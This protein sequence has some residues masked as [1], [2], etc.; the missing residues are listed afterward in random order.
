MGCQVQTVMTGIY[1]G[2]THRGQSTVRVGWRSNTGWALH[3][4][5]RV[6]SMRDSCHISKRSI[7]SLGVMRSRGKIRWL[8]TL[9]RCSSNTPI[10]T[11]TLYRRPMSFQKSIRS[12]SML[13]SREYLPTIEVSTAEVRLGKS[14]RICGSLSLLA[15]QE[16]VASIL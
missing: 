9:R 2:P 15:L 4:L 10:T 6:I 14:L 1:S 7:T 16:A 12:L 3:L 8:L 11:S 13:S 5:T